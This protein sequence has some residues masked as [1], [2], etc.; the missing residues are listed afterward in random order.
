[1][2]LA[3]VST[4]YVTLEM[5]A[6]DDDDRTTQELLSE[7]QSTRMSEIKNGRLGLYGAEYSKCNHMV[8]LGFKGLM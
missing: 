4:I 6:D 5:L 8:T 7:R 3:T 2:V 1:M